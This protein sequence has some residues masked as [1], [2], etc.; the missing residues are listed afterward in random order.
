[1]REKNVELVEEII[2]QKFYFPKNM[3]NLPKS[4]PTAMDVLYLIMLHIV[5]NVDKKFSC[6]SFIGTKKIMFPPVEEKLRMTTSISSKALKTEGQ[7]NV[8]VK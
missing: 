6:V 3:K 7:T 4:S 2:F 5:G 8:P 1:M